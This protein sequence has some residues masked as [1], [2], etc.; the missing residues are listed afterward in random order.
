M[1]RLLKKDRSL[2]E[3]GWGLWVLGF[4]VT[5]W[6]RDLLVDES[7]DQERQLIKG[8]RSLKPGGK[9]AKQLTR[10]APPELRRMQQIAGPEAMPR[11]LQMLTAV[12]LGTLRAEDYPEED[13]E[14]LQGAVLHQL[15]PELATAPDLPTPQEVAAGM[16]KLSSQASLKQVIA[17]LKTLPAARL[18]QYRNEAQWL[19]ERFTDPEARGTARV[20]R[21]EFIAF[22]KLRHLDP[23]GARGVPALMQALGQSRPPASPIQRW[24]HARRLLAAHPAIPTP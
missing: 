18:E 24:H 19:V 5:E 7:T 11:L 17:A 6:A 10:R 23:E 16:A 3:A 15:W 13:W 1:A 21:D 8:A 9:A 2:V 14:L 20:S 4:P 22:L 12:P